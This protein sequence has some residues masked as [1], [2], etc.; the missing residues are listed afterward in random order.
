MKKEYITCEVVQDLLPLYL[1]GCCSEQSGK[2]VEEHLAG[3]SDCRERSR[4]FR[5]N[6]P[7]AG[8]L[9]EPDTNKIRR[10]VRKI[11]RWKVIG[12][13]SLWLTLAIIFVFLPAW[14]YVRG[15]GLTYGN[16]KAAYTAYAFT[17]ALISGNYEKAYDYLAIRYNYEDLLA[18]DLEDAKKRGD[19][20]AFAEEE[21]IRKIAENGFE[22]YD[23]EARKK[24]R[25]N[26]ETLEELDEMLC[27][28]SGF[29]IDKQDRGWMAY[30]DVKTTSGQDF[31]LQLDIYPEGIA[32]IIPSAHCYSED[33]VTGEITIDEELEQKERMLSRFYNSPTINETVMELLYG[34]TDWDWTVLFTY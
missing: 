32:H 25:K 19:K 23:A 11:N 14:N 30:F 17:D 24:F 8:A 15:S 31:T 4:L 18:T 28:R 33:F 5:E 12:K 10:G 2:I 1:D 27:F 29:R 9:E 22:W 21:G 3:C 20:D 26:M 34:N 7:Q 16:L 13:I 6:L